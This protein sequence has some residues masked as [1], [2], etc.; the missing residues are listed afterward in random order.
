MPRKTSIGPRKLKFKQHEMKRYTN[1]QRTC[2]TQDG[3]TKQEPAFLSISHEE[4]KDVV[5]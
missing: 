1:L 5:R 4:V 2:D 3:T